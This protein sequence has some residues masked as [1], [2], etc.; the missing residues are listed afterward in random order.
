MRRRGGG[1]GA[2]GGDGGDDERRSSATA[3]R[4]SRDY[5]ANGGLATNHADFDTGADDDDDKDGSSKLNKLTLLDAVFLMGL[6]DSQGYLSFW[7]DNIS[8]VLRGCILMEL[9]LR[10]RISSV[11]EVRKRPFPERIIQVI[12][13]RNTGEVILDEAL[14]LI[15]A[16]PGQSV[17]NWIDLLS[18]ETWNLMK[19]GYQLKQVRE[20]IA[21]GLVDKG[22]LRTEK[23]NF[24]LFDMATH[25]VSNAAVKESLVQRVIDT[26]LGRGP[27]PDSRM[28]ATVCAAYA[29]NV[30]ENALANLSHHQRESAF[31]KVLLWQAFSSFIHSFMCVYAFVSIVALVFVFIV[32]F[33]FVFIVA[34]VFIIR[35]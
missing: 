24:V 20:R 9:A 15:K 1:G 14:K 8:Y 10:N 4:S 32:A 13:D 28:I 3:K 26:L 23:R 5:A 16:D 35:E 34:F 19:V 18:G 27:A 2:T 25:P 22:V 29:A 12:D 7:N 11:K 31:S 6:K 33:V 17:A 30:L 21:K